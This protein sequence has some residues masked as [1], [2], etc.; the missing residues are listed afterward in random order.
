M[1]QKEY[2]QVEKAIAKVKGNLDLMNVF[3]QDDDNNGIGQFSD[4]VLGLPC[5]LN[6][7]FSLT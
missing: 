6:H 3:Y 2:V 4:R 1:V 5:S 7:P